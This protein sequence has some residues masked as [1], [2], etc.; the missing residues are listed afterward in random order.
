MSSPVGGTCIK[1]IYY[2]KLQKNEYLL[3][4]RV[5]ERGRKRNYWKIYSI[6]THTGELISRSFHH[7]LGW[8]FSYPLSLILLWVCVLCCCFTPGMM[9]IIFL[10]SLTHSLVSRMMLRSNQICVCKNCTLFKKRLIDWNVYDKNI[11]F[12][13]LVMSVFILLFLSFYKTINVSFI[14][15]LSFHCSN[16][17]FYLSLSLFNSFLAFFL[18]KKKEKKRNDSSFC[19]LIVPCCLCFKPRAHFTRHT[20]AFHVLTNS[21]PHLSHFLSFYL[22]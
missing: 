9:E 1:Y 19:R 3:V 15:S 11:S 7:P 17:N 10:L 14:F 16:F 5:R 18:Q 13:F 20:T 22:V 6:W 21:F 12:Y 4:G 2:K 8:W